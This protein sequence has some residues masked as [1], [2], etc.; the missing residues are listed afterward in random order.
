MKLCSECR[1][2]P[3]PFVLVTVIALIVAAITW[4]T[5]GLSQI[6]P[7]LRIGAGLAVFVA[8]EGTLVHYVVSCIRRHCRHDQA[9]ASGQR[10][11]SGRQLSSGL[12][13]G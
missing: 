1:S 5:L 13:R 4:L 6:E 2:T 11:D 7:M 8:V 9:R 10:R 3:W 12:S